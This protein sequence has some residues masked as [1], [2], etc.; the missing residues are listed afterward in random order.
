[1][2]NTGGSPGCVLNPRGSAAGAAA[3]GGAAAASSLIVG[4]TPGLRGSG[5]ALIACVPLPRGG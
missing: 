1:M 5:A 4:V 3:G 2:S